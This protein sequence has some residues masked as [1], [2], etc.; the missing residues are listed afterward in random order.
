MK[1][2]YGY[3]L[4]AGAIFTLNACETF[5]ITSFEDMNCSRLNKEIARYQNLYESADA[6][7]SF[8]NLY[9]LTSDKKEEDM[10]INSVFHAQ[11]EKDNARDYLRALQ[12]IEARKNC[13]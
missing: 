10:A 1:P 9:R 6:S 3:I 7:L 11:T 2:I 12:S 5:D 4:S 13:K 8:A